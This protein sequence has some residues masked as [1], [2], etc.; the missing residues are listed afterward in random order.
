MVG[1]HRSETWLCTEGAKKQ[2]ED[3][4]ISGEEAYAG[5]LWKG[6]HLRDAPAVVRL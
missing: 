2:G 3:A 1:V 5:A 6:I 4:H